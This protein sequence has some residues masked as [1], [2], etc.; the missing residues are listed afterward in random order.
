MTTASHLL[1][2]AALIERI[3]ALGDKDALSELDAR[4]GMTLFAIAYTVL[5]DPDAADAA[6]AAAM[7]QVWRDAASFDR[8]LG[9][10]GM[11]L[12]ELTRRAARRHVNAARQPRT[13]AVARSAATPPRPPRPPR[14][15]SRSRQGRVARLVRVALARAVRFAAAFAL[16]TLLVR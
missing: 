6:V 14:R 4:H 11:W 1:P 5:L 3:A 7:R 8:R 15:R 9:T 2:D 13:P 12:A 16:P 10:A